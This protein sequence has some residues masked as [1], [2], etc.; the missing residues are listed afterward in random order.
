L[1][2]L[3]SIVSYGNR[4][5]NYSTAAEYFR[6]HFLAAH[7]KKDAFQRRL[8]VVSFSPIQPILL[9]FNPGLAAFHDYAGKCSFFERERDRIRAV[10]MWLSGRS[11]YADHHRKR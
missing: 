8:Y 1:S 5:N 9:S 2:P 10:H 11:S 3:G 7:K 4:P 6:T